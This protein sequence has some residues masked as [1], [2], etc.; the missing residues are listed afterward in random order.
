MA[1]RIIFHKADH[2]VCGS[3]LISAVADIATAPWLADWHCKFWIGDASSK[4]RELPRRLPD[5][6]DIVSK[7]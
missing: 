1:R 6:A 3:R 2:V 4:F 7:I 5:K